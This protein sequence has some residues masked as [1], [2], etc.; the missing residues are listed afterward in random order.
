[1]LLAIVAAL[2]WG[3]GDAETTA[4]PTPTPSATATSTSRGLNSGALLSLVIIFTLAFVVLI[5]F[6]V[7]VAYRK[8]QRRKRRKEAGV[9]EQLKETVPTV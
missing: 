1:M 3:A 9:E 5:A 7:V 4:E 2:A 8:I 6:A